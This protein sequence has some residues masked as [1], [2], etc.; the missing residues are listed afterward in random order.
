MSETGLPQE[1]KVNLSRALNRERLIRLNLYYV[2][3]KFGLNLR[4][5]S[6]P[7]WAETRTGSLHGTASPHAVGDVVCR[8]EEASRAVH[9]DCGGVTTDEDRDGGVGAALECYQ[10]KGSVPLGAQPT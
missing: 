8:G 10:N 3:R 9:E 4:E 5:G 2:N 6:S 1:D 7:A